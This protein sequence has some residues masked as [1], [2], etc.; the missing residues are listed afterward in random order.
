VTR[1]LNCGGHV[2]DRYARVQGNNNDEVREC[3][4]CPDSD[5]GRRVNGAAAGLNVESRKMTTA[6]THQS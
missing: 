2:T 5:M 1:C 6:A 4:S 3:P